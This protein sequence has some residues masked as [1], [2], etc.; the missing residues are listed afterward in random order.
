MSHG[1]VDLWEIPGLNRIIPRLLKM[2]ADPKGDRSFSARGNRSQFPNGF[3]QQILRIYKNMPIADQKNIEK[4]YWLDLI[5]CDNPIIVFICK[6][7]QFSP[8]DT[9]DSS[10]RSPPPTRC[11]SGNQMQEIKYLKGSQG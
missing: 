1:H 10:D 4:C 2:A 8:T 3:T 5:S 7:Q 6:D 11:R 9:A